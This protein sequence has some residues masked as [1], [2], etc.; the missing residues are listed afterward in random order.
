MFDIGFWELL[1][2]GIIALLVLG[3]ERLPSAIRSTID[4]VRSIKSVANGFKQEVSN[5]LKTHEL[6]EHL[7]KAEKAGL[8]NV[9][10]D[11]RRS[12]EELK[13]AAASVQTPYEPTKKSNSTSEQDIIS[14]EQKKQNDAD[15]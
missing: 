14:I 8:E 5:Q 10:E 15:Q 2:I 9:G 7:K 1:V 11:I 6:H 12:V 4:T 3:P 13:A